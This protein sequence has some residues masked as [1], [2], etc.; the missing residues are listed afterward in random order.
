MSTESIITRIRPGM[1][2][3]SAD[4]QLIGKVREVWV[5]SDP[6]QSS[7]RCDEEECSRLEVQRGVARAYIPYNAIAAVEGKAVRLTLDAATVNEKGWHRK[8]RWIADEPPPDM[9]SIT[10]TFGS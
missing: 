2:V 8:P 7:E 1:N 9:P 5:G 10:H 6:R 4:G 3:Q